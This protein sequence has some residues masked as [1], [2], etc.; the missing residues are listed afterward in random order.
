MEFKFRAVDHRPPN[1]FPP[2]SSSFNPDP[3][4]LELE[5]AQIREE[6]IASEI[7]RRRALEAEVRRELMMEWEM[8][9]RHIASEPGL[10]FVHRLIMQVDPRPPLM[11]PHFNINR[12]CWRPEQLLNWFPPPPPSLPMLPPRVTEVLDTEVKDASE[13]NK[14]KL[15]ILAKPDPNHVIGAKRKTPPPAGTGELMLPLI[16]LK[17]KPNKEWSCAICQVSTTSEKGLTEH[18]QGRKH[19]ANEARLR[20]HRM[21]KNSNTTTTLPKKL[22]QS[23]LKLEDREK[24]KNKKDEL[25]VKREKKEEKFRKK[26][27][28]FLEKKREPTAMDEVGMTPEL[29]IKKYKFWCQMCLVGAYSEVVMETHK[30]GRRHIARLMELDEVNAASP[31]TITTNTV[32]EQAVSDGSEMPKV[33]DVVADEAN[34]KLKDV[35]EADSCKFWCQMCLFSTHSEAVMETH[36]KGKMHIARLRELDGKTAA[37]S[38]TTTTT[39]EITEQTSSDGTQMSKVTDVVADKANEKVMDVREADSYNPSPFVN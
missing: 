17:V 22:R 21:E 14:N 19:K 11:Q 28:D 38:A 26:Y 35:P 39:D 27:E 20:A 34:E 33:T 4:R 23:D 15:I 36:K 25:L 29:S 5:K 16:S 6:I 32:T 8:A 37:A 9:A 30:K 18:L 3:T 13:G 10:S 31:A 1:Y 7:A 24:L 12:H 2:P